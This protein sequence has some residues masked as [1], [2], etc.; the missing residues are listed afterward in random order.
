MGSVVKL[1]NAWLAT[2]IYSGYCSGAKRSR[3]AMLSKGISRLDPLWIDPSRRGSVF[4]R[5]P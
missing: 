3:M 2:R 1:G 4:R 5:N